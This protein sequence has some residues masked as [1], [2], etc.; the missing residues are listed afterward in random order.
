LLD[1]RPAVQSFTQS[2]AAFQV[3]EHGFG[4]HVNGVGVLG[5]SQLLMASPQVIEHV[6][7]PEQIRIALA[8]RLTY[9][10]G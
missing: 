1:G 5:P 9:L 3:A 7:E 4:D 2:A 10:S 6:F 8:H